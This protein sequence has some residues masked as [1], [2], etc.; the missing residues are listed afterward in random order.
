M[1]LTPDGARVRQ[2]GI[3]R[4]RPIM[5]LH[6]EKLTGDMLTLAPCGDFCF[7]IV[8]TASISNNDVADEW[9]DAV[10]H[11]LDARCLIFDHAI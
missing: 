8:G 2:R 9:F 3:A 5:K 4:L 7:G 6:V 10:Q 11:A 1:C